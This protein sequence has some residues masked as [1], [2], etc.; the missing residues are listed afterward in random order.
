MFPQTGLPYPSPEESGGR[1]AAYVPRS[2]A[3]SSRAKFPAQNFPR[4]RTAAKCFTGLSTK[5]GAILHFP[6]RSASPRKRGCISS[7]CVCT[8]LT[9]YA[10]AR[11]VCIG[12]RREE[13]SCAR[14]RLRSRLL[15]YLPTLPTYPRSACGPRLASCRVGRARRTR[16]PSRTPR[17]GRALP[18]V[19]AHVH[20]EERR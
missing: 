3:L 19:H 9:Q 8:L 17:P 16:A 11:H 13:R 6:A 5:P 4:E 14:W 18:C 15:T 20:G 1:R 12:A 7:S 2:R 10:M